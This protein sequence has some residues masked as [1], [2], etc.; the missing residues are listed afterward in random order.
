MDSPTSLD[1][2]A[3]DSAG[4]AHAVLAEV[5]CTWVESEA[6]EGADDASTTRPAST[7]EPATAVILHAAA[8]MLVLEAANPRQKLPALGTLVHVQ[9]ERLKVTGRLAEHG[10][11]GR[12]LV[13]IGSRPVRRSI[14][15]RVSLPGTL[16]S[17]TLAQ[18][19]QVEIVDLT[20]GGARVRG[21]EL[22]VNSQVALDFTPPGRDE[23]VT[24]RALV[25][26]ATEGAEHPWIGLIF[27][28]VALRGGR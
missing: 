18:P 13:C 20:T 25:A 23:S 3:T 4:P 10:R 22:P 5:I 11:G 2:R 16:R 6:A 7:V 24:V 1:P 26:H 19:L 8:D 17:P 27:R 9:G 12:F 28:L 15:L 21:V 14:R